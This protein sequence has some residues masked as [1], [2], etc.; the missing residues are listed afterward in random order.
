M[1]PFQA[2]YGYEP[3]TVTA[4]LPGSTAVAKVDQELRSR[5]EL[6]QILKKNLEKAQSRMKRF[7]DLKHSER[8][9][10][11]GDLVYLKL[12]QYKQNSVQRR[13]FHKLSAKYYGILKCWRR[14]ALWHTN[15][16]CHPL[17]RYTMSF[18]YLY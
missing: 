7:Y 12:Q 6:L 18:M 17:L 10:E 2:L 9:F 14:L 4:Y 3:P 1:S 11:V 5:D 13:V 15:S 8:N 16:N